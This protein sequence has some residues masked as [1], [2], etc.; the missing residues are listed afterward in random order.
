MELHGGAWYYAGHSQ[1]LG[2]TTEA[3]CEYYEKGLLFPGHKG[4][5]LAPYLNALP[6]P[7]EDGYVILP[8]T[9]GLGMELNWDY[10]EEHRVP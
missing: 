7:V 2:A 1:I 4:D 3:T 5:A 9:P 6:D 8:T 10:I